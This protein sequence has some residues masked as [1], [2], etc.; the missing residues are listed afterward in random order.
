[1]LVSRQ[2]PL[3]CLSGFASNSAEP[4]VIAPSQGKRKLEKAVG[5]QLSRRLPALRANGKAGFAFR[6]HSLPVGS[7]T[8]VCGGLGLATPQGWAFLV[9]W[10]GNGFPLVPPCRA[11]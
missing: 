4:Q 5:F 3:P 1:M 6:R 10:K 9:L 8:D 11:A 2:A 7:S